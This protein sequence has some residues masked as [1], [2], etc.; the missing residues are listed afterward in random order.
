MLPSSVRQVL[1]DWSLIVERP[2]RPDLDDWELDCYNPE[3]AA[4]LR[5]EDDLVDIAQKPFREL[6]AIADAVWDMSNQQFLWLLP[7][8]LWYGCLSEDCGASLIAHAMHEKL[9][10]SKRWDQVKPRLS[11]ETLRWLQS[12]SKRIIPDSS[13]SRSV[14]DDWSAVVDRPPPPPRP[15]EKDLTATWNTT[16]RN[17]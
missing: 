17:L 5:S 1:V 6:E 7:V 2:D 14:F 3:L 8:L 13:N 10:T 12:M 16:V 4:V 15:G 9:P 11:K